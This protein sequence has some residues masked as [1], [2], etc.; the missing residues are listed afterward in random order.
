MKREDAFNQLNERLFIGRRLLPHE[1]PKGINHVV[2]LTCEFPQPRGDL[3]Y[4]YH[5]YPILD[6]HVPEPKKLRQ[7]AAEVAMLPGKIYIHC[8]E[9]HGRTGLFTSALL[10]EQA[11]FSTVDEALAYVKSKR[12]QVRLSRRQMLVLQAEYA[13]ATSASS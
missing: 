10:V 12:P 7:W 4:T 9:G 1:I 5:C 6:G 13:E 8:A 3:F 2:D 11:E